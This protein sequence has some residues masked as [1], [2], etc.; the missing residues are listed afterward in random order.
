MYND[1][2][3]AFH[4]AVLCSIALHGVLLFGLSVLRDPENRA[5]APGPIVA[6]L[7]QPAPSAAPAAAPRPEPVKPSA[8]EKPPPAVKV[9][10]VKPVRPRP[11]AKKAETKAP[12]RAAPAPSA[13][14]T[15]P[16]AEAP[17]APPAPSAAPAPAGPPAAAVARVEPTP[18]PAP[19]GAEA[20][21]AGSLARYRLQLISAA[22][23]YKRYP[24]AAMD[25][26]WEGDVVVRMVIGANGM[27]SALSVKSSSG[28]QVLDQQAIE[29]F[30]RA[31]PLVQIPPA[32]RGREFSIELRAIYSLKDQESS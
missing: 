9:P 26:N 32:L 25:N 29:M 15:E 31:K 18:A 22:R 1:Q 3:R 16:V 7:V 23:K 11:L 4:C 2:D 27:I 12:A 30:K 13:P 20:F 6:R 28:H 5:P 14:V 19:P 10:A 17:P 24:R 8:Q 21:Y